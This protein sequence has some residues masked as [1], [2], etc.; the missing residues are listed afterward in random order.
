MKNF[1]LSDHLASKQPASLG[2][3]FDIHRSLLLRDELNLQNN[4]ILN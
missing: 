2:W 4:V 1:S 3:L